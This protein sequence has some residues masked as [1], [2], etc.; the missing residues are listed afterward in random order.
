M[1]IKTKTETLTD[2]ETLAIETALQ[3]M[4]DRGEASYTSIEVLLRKVRAAR[5]MRVITE[6]RATSADHVDGFDR[7]DLGESPDF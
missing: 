6:I 2:W 7:D 1:A 4:Q 5:K 3:K